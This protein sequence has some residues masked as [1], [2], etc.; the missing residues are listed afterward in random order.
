MILILYFYVVV[1]TFNLLVVVVTLV[2]L[3]SITCVKSLSE[4]L[5]GMNEDLLSSS[6]HSVC[7][8]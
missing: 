2:V 3:V 7:R 6:T 1:N 4:D 8:K 5:I